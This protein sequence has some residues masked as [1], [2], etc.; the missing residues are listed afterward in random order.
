MD[1]SKLTDNEILDIANPL[2]EN[3]IEA[4]EEA[5]YEKL[6][7]DFTKRL[8]SIV[9]K[10]T[11]EKQLSDNVLGKFGKREL[12]G[13][14]HKKHSIFVV[15]KQ[16]FV[17]SDDEFLAEIVIVHKDGRYLVDHDWFR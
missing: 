4:T 9:T 5:D 3:I 10:E 12:L 15:W 8:K 16:W 13:I 1:F 17:E 11:F 2:L 6:S 7:K 14:I